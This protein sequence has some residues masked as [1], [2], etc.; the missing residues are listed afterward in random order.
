MGGRSA[1]QGRILPACGRTHAAAIE[2]LK[3]GVPI[4]EVV[5]ATRRTAENAG[6]TL[7]CPRIGHGIGLDY[8]EKPLLTEN[9]NRVLEAGNVVEVHIQFNLPGTGGFYV[10]LGDVCHVTRDGVEVF[11]K[12][13]LESFRA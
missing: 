12:F 9:N 2:M 10:P 8:G 7:H 1:R 6:V 4:S 3:P 13:P 11:T 5:A